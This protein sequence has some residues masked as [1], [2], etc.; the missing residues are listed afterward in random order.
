MRRLL[1]CLLPVAGFVQGVSAQVDQ[2]A[3][4]AG[5]APAFEEQTR[6]PV[7]PATQLD[8]RVFASGLEFP[9]GIA[10][11]DDGGFLVTQRGGTMIILDAEGEVTGAVSGLP[12]VVAIGQGG[13]LDVAVQDDVVFWTYAKPVGSGAALAAGRGILGADGTLSDVTDIFVQ[14]PAVQGGRHFGSRI[15]PME[16]GSVW[17]TSGDRGAPSLVQDDT[18]T[19]GKVI[20]VS[21]QGVAEVWSTGHRNIQGAAFAPDGLWTVEHGPRGGDELNRPEQGGNYGWPVVSYGIDY[22]GAD[23]GA[24]I[25]VSQG[26]E[27]PVYYWDPVIAPAGMVFYPPEGFE[28]WRGDLL[29]SSLNPGGVN[30]LRLHDGLVVGEEHLLGDLGRVRDLHVLPDGDVLVLQDGPRADILRVTPKAQ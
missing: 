6:A 27:P 8:R 4:N 30:R 3:P 21:P 14:T 5:F 20:R 25:A 24:G 19:V 18:T 26:F 17:I 7:L 13:L 1:M 2:G 23:V 11:L 12:E 15:L 28:G 9:W 16:D 10:A 22:S 29:V